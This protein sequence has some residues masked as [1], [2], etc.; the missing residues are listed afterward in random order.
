MLGMAHVAADET[1]GT[2]IV[3]AWGGV[4][5]R[6]RRGAARVVGGDLLTPAEVEVL[7]LV[8]DQP[9]LTVRETA[10][11]L[12][13]AANTVSTLVGGLA[14][15]GLLDRRRDERDRRAVRLTVTAA[16]RRRMRAWHD[17]RNRLLTLAL[18][19][20]SEDDRAALETS[21][22]PMRRLAIALE[23]LT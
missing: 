15:R 9:G 16:A 12:H 3:D 4:R 13:L 18:A 6:L 19:D 21:L 7:R 20:L 10:D 22:E 8:A 2:D 11:A 17:E 23:E 1:L 14:E 5:R